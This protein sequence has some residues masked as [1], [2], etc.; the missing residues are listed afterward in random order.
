MQVR[1]LRTAARWSGRNLRP[2]LS[3]GCPEVAVY[4]GVMVTGLLR[5]AEESSEQAREG[6]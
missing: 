2:V 1:L 3:P 6:T 5:W 4:L